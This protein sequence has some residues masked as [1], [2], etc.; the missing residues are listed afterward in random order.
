MLVASG[1]TSGPVAAPPEV[2]ALLRPP[3][4][5]VVFLEALGSGVR[6]YECAPNPEEPSAFEWTFRAPEATLVDRSGRSIGK[7]YSGPTWESI[8]GSSVVG[9]I[10]A[11]YYPPDSSAIPWMRLA[12]KS[13]TGSGVFGQTKSIQRVATVGG[14]APSAPCSS[15]NAKQIA[16]VPYSATY[17]FYRA[18][19]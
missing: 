3:F 19:Y 15:A 4:G 2:P 5:Q 12:G 1:C 16:R 13:T 7:H 14:I 10:K 17:Y 8:D 9:E 6:I 18:A 11:R